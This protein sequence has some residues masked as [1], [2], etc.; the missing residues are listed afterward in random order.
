MASL[1]LF[2]RVGFGV[3][4]FDTL[5]ADATSPDRGDYNGVFDVEFPLPDTRE[6]SDASQDAKLVRPSE[7][8]C[9]G[10]NGYGHRR[11]AHDARGIETA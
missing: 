8:A 7:L 9:I 10:R 1:K 3:D 5:Q 6:A 11:F 4:N 2:G